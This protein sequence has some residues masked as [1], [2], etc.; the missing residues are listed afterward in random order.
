MFHI[1]I[2]ISFFIVY[3][4]ILVLKPLSYLSIVYICMY[5]C[6]YQHIAYLSN[7]HIYIYVYIYI[8]SSIISTWTCV[9]YV[10]I[11]YS[12][13]L[14]HM[15]YLHLPACWWQHSCGSAAPAAFFGADFSLRW[16]A[17]SRVATLQQDWWVYGFGPL[18]ING[19][20]ISGL[21]VKPCWLSQIVYETILEIGSPYQN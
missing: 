5:I 8:Y 17:W 14:D 20:W 7:N 1:Y 15:V 13:Y 3:I 6:E 18:L 2:Y 4:S 19:I 12:I 21:P 10:C 9:I 16:V 11:F